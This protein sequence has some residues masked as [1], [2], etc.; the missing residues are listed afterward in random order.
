VELA[1]ARLVLEV[2]ESAV[3]EGRRALD[4][5]HALDALGVNIALDD[6]GTGQ[7]SLG[8]LRTCPVHVLKLDKSFVDEVT[9]SDQ[10]AA[11]A[12][13]VLQMADALG[14]QAVAEGIETEAQARKL[15]E[16][17]YQRAQGYHFAK[18]L[19]ASELPVVPAGAVAQ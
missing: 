19:P 16:I 4:A 15:A 2:T 6:F 1:P 10:R 9:T 12:T 13:A 3:L 18:P 11:V 7:S 5:L 8:L 14:L 17:G